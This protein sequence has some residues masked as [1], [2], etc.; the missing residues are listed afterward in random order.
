MSAMRDAAV[1]LVLALVA[2]SVRID[3]PA[4]RASIVPEAQAAALPAAFPQPIAGPALDTQWLERNVQALHVVRLA[5]SMQVTQ[6]KELATIVL[7]DEECGAKL[8]LLDSQAKLAPPAEPPPP[9]SR[10]T[11]G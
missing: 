3:R 6:A 2:L 4:G 8:I 1:V 9:A 7:G 10:V 11:L 5:G